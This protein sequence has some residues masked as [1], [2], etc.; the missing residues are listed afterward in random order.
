[1]GRKKSLW[2]DIEAL[3]RLARSGRR[4]ERALSAAAPAQRA[5]EAASGQTS[6]RRAVA[7]LATLSRTI[8]L[9]PVERQVV[10]IRRNEDTAKRSRAKPRP[11]PPEDSV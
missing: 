2:T 6:S 9:L 8:E 1:M 3:T 10:E 11:R 7:A 4:A 5:I